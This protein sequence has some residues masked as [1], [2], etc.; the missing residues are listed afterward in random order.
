MDSGATHGTIATA[1]RQSR[2]WSPRADDLPAP[3]TRIHLISR[4]QARLEGECCRWRAS[5]S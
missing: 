5:H 4:L 3:E 1:W 2:R